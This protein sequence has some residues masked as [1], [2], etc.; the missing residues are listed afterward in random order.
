MDFRLQPPHAS[1]PTLES[2]FFFC[3]FLRADYQLRCEQLHFTILM[4]ERLNEVPPLN[5]MISELSSPMFQILE[6]PNIDTEHLVFPV[7]QP[8]LHNNEVCLAIAQLFLGHRGRF[9]KLYLFMS[10]GVKGGSHLVK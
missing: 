2:P 6:H 1:V 10:N 4:L 3:S 9:N 5:V 8:H 7:P